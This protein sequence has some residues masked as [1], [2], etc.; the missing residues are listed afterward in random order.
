MAERRKAVG[1]TRHANDFKR[2][3][4]DT[5]VN[6]PPTRTELRKPMGP[7]IRS[8]LRALVA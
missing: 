5:L 4:H 7:S 2:T 8:C 1:K 3:P 6:L